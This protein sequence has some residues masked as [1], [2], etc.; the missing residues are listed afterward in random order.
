MLEKSNKIIFKIIIC[1]ISRQYGGYYH[2]WAN[3]YIIAFIDDLSDDKKCFNPS[4]RFP[5][6]T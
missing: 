6:G 1:S 5:V 3:C 4:K 2:Q